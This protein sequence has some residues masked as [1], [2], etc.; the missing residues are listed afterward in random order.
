MHFFYFTQELV[1]LEKERAARIQ[2]A[3]DEARRL[4]KEARLKE[5]QVKYDTNATFQ[6]NFDCAY[7]VLELHRGI[8][9]NSALFYF[10]YVAAIYFLAGSTRKSESRR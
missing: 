8:F 6:V 9:L 2:A 4:E 1:R 7:T 3:Q 5:A 10:S